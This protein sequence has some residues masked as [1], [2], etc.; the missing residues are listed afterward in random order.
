MQSVTKSFLCV[1]VLF[2]TSVLSA[3]H[4]SDSQ[5]VQSEHESY[6][7]AGTAIPVSLPRLSSSHLKPGD[8]IVAKTTQ[9]IVLED[10][11]EVP[12]GSKLT[13]HVV[14][15]IPQKPSSVAIEFDTLHFHGHEISVRV[16]LRA[17]TTFPMA[18][19]A[20]HGDAL[21]PSPSPVFM[22]Y[23]LIGGDFFRDREGPVYTSWGAKVGMSTRK[24]VFERLAG[25]QALRDS[26]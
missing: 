23:R 5:P 22:M 3:Q 17:M 26:D 4:I 2:L 21:D 7:P 13:G 9:V 18:Q 10:E 15:A 19:S 8:K 24:G 12:A 25:L 16:A 1:L 6:L 14:D 20:R 11:Q